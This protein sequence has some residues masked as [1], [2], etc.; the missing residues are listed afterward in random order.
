MAVFLRYAALGRFFLPT[1]AVA[2]VLAGVGAVRL[3]TAPASAP[4]RLA[5]AT[6]VVVLS[7]PLLAPRVTGL[8][9]VV[10]EVTTRA[11]LDESIEVAVDAAGGPEVL[12]QCDVIVLDGVPL[13][14]PALAWKVDLPLR[15]VWVAAPTDRSYA[16][17]T[18]PLGNEDRRVRALPS[19]EQTQLARTDAWVVHAVGC[20]AGR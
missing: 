14:Q 9:D 6:V 16:I 15:R 20:A 10:D 3:V 5:V 8:A 17:L 13:L 1:A 12:A 11:T 19:G 4:A 2:C 18:A 7:A